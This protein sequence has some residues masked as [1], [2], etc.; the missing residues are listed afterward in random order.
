MM[1]L[2]WLDGLLGQAEGKSYQS[3]AQE[4]LLGPLGMAD[5]GFEAPSEAG[6]RPAAAYGD[7]GLTMTHNRT[8]HQASSAIAPAGARITTAGDLGRFGL[9]MI[10][11]GSSA[12]YAYSARHRSKR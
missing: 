5:S 4:V 7:L 1:D 9:A 12:G 6:P 8:D 2:P 11:G 3:L 10:G